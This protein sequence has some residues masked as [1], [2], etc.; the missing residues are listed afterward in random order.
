MVHEDEHTQVER[1][2]LEEVLNL[3]P[4]HLT[5]HELV[6]KIGADRD[7]LDGETIRHAIRDL[8]ASGLLRYVGDVVAPTYAALRAAFLLL[9]P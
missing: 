9:R 6:L 2:V 5:I 8:R 7:V 1:A 4:D 3:H